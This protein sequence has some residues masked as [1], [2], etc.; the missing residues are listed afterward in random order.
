MIELIV[1]QPNILLQDGYTMAFLWPLFLFCKSHVEELRCF[2]GLFC[3][4]GLIYSSSP[5]NFYSGWV[6][7][8]SS[9]FKRPL[10]QYWEERQ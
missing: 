8:G 5:L 10:S 4:R 2:P 1:L 7:T 6:L 3:F 9:N